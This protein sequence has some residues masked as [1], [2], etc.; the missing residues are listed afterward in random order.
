MKRMLFVLFVVIVTVSVT[1]AGMA[2]LPLSGHAATPGQQAATTQRTI[3]TWGHAE[4]AVTPNQASMTIGVQ[5][6]AGQARESLASNN[7]KIQRVMA[8]VTKLGVAKTAIQTSD[9]S[10]WYDSQQRNYVTTH[11]LGIRLDSVD[12]VGS[13]L[14]AAI[15]AGANNS[16]GV[17]FGLKNPA[18]ARSQALKVAIADARK[19]AETIAQALGTTIH[20]TVSV[21]EAT[22]G[23]GTKGAIGVGG[24]GGGTV[25]QPGQYVVA[26]DVNV[27]YTCG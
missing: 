12:K 5:S 3:S 14:D 8:A 4:V 1:V 21:D 11:N 23:Y 6:R 15:R 20:Q 16:F 9:L 18:T 25:V 27:T 24:G 22:A 7:T 19:R 26:A 17:S 10:L 13:V 2:F